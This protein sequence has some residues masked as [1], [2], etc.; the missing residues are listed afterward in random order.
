MFY[1][2]VGLFLVATVAGRLWW[3]SYASSQLSEVVAGIRARG[4]PLEWSEFAPEP[5]PDDQNAA[6]LYLEAT[7][8]QFLNSTAS[9]RYYDFDQGQFINPAKTKEEKRLARLRDM[10][11]YLLE[12][13]DFRRE[14][15]EDVAE[16]IK[17]CE[18]SFALCRRARGL[19]RSDWGMDFSGEAL[20]AEHPPLMPARNIA[21]A[22]CL[23][24]LEAHD[25][26][27]DALAVE[28][29]RD[30]LAI[31]RSMRTVP[32]MTCL[33]VGMSVESLAYAT[34]E[35]ISPS[36]KVA[37]SSAAVAREVLEEFVA[38]L[39]DTRVVK[40]GM[41]WAM[42]GQRAEDLDTCERF[43]EKIA[44]AW[45]ALP[46]DMVLGPAWELD[47]VRLLRYNDAIVLAS[48][49]KTMPDA[50]SV[51]RSTIGS[52]DEYWEKELPSSALVA[53]LSRML[54]ISFESFF[55][56]HFNGIAS[57][58]M[59]GV[60]LAIRLYELDHG[61]RLET[62]AEL[63]PDYLPHV[64][65]DPFAAESVKLRYAPDAK[66][67]ILYSV[68]ANGLDDGGSLELYE[69]LEYWKDGDITFFIDGDRPV[70]EC[71]WEEERAA[72]RRLPGDVTPTTATSPTTSP[73]QPAPE[74]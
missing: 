57:C 73:A 20:L 48:K 69:A 12:H 55:E 44:D 16:I 13:K 3:G 40:E 34:I 18:E 70:G 37:D 59:T 74:R 42:M 51:I 29:I 32:S 54:A 31:A 21:R 60:A 35:T 71:D 66:R 58:R 7:E 17:L 8:V 4:E 65:D 64:P 15:R 27:D 45:S 28:Y 36:L 61:R 25:A 10:L 30:T 2:L 47:N 49:Q 52:A 23:A 9:A 11:P 63:V 50:Q 62:L 5:V 33:L 56:N 22:L 26:G 6:L 41:V 39:L 68:G 19:E 24:A 46:V 53:P 43:R 38:E 72:R 67:A 14:R 1:G